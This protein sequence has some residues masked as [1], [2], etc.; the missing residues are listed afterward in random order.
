MWEL[1]PLSL[2]N[3]VEAHMIFIR[4][5][6]YFLSVVV[7]TLLISV[8]ISIAQ[9]IEFGSNNGDYLE[10]NTTKLY[11]E[12]Y[13]DGVP[14]VL[15][16]GGLGSI[17]NFKAVI[18]ELARHFKVIAVDSP[19][20]GRSEQIDSLS[21][22]IMAEYIATF[23]DDLKLNSVN[24]LGYS[25]GA[26]TGLLVSHL[27]PQKVHR[28][29]FGAGALS[30]SASTPEGLAMLMNFSAD[31]L[32]PE[33]EESYRQ[34]SPNPDYWDEFIQDSKNMWLDEVWISREILP[35]IQ[36]KVLV[37]FGDR[38][39]FIPLKHALEIYELIPES[40]LG[41]LPNTPHEMFQYPAITNPIVIDFLL[42]D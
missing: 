4:F 40:E 5:K 10:V 37:L 28:L 26:I 29:I 13:G 18:P 22:Q 34:K 14:L 24:I 12:T 9:A 15:L 42:R 39:P 3:N 1:I 6:R 31:M 21:Y 16:H 8:N 11:Y 19:G 33:W 36:T 20:H 2:E 41:I 35:E 27:R 32:P 23:I 30:P 17:S 38:D 7:I 25:D